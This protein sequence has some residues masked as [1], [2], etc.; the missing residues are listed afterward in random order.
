VTESRKKIVWDTVRIVRPICIFLM[1]IAVV[2][3]AM[4]IKGWA[5][6]SLLLAGLIVLIGSLLVIQVHRVVS[7]LRRRSSII[8]EAAAQAEAHYVD[9]LRR[10]VT[11]VEARDEYKRGHS[12]RVGRLSAEIAQQLGLSKDKC[13]LLDLAGQLHDI[14]MLAVPESVLA[15]PSRLA[16]GEFRSV[17][18][19]PRIGYDVLKPLASLSD[20]LPAILYHHERM[21]GTGYPAGIAKAEIP[22]GARI[23]AVADSYDAITHDRPHREAMGAMAAMAEL[24]RCTPAAYDTGCVEALAEVV[25]LPALQEA[26]ACAAAKQGAGRNFR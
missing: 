7:H 14:G 9:V 24:R 4:A 13:A 8:A 26:F 12:E 23:L 3:C 22:L 20:V 2:A 25:H 6:T 10:I 21:N 5:F 11:F 19:H 1:A 16:I 18:R 15:R 17:K